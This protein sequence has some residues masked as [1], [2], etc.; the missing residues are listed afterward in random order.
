MRLTGRRLTALAALAVGAISAV[1]A[2]AGAP[3]VGVPALV[4]LLA[5]AGVLSASN[6][7]AAAMLA[8]VAAALIPIVAGWAQAS[9]LVGLLAFAM[10]LWRRP[11]RKPLVARP[12]VS[13]WLYGLVAVLAVLVFAL[14]WHQSFI[15][16]SPGSF[17]WSRPR[18]PV[19]GLPLMMAVVVCAA[20]VNALFEELLW[21]VVLADLPGERVSGG[22]AWPVLVSAAFGLSH[23]HGTPGGWI[24]VAATF[25][26]G[27]AMVALRRFAGGSIVVCVVA[28]FAA[29][30]ILLWGLYG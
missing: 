6:R 5:L 2:S 15:A 16:I 30:L 11:D 18:L 10:L 20:A 19:D 13:A 26:F 29:D 8:A 21:R 25:C 23:L 4:A 27:L 1:Y 7:H 9:P 12:P 14:W 28:H 17:G 22:L 3:I 24:G